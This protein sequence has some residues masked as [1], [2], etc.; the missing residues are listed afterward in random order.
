VLLVNTLIVTVAFLLVDYVWHGL[1]SPGPNPYKQDIL[2]KLIWT[3]VLAAAYAHLY[4]K[5]SRLWRPNSD[6]AFLF[7]N[8]V[9]DPADLCK[10]SWPK[11]AN[12]LVFSVLFSVVVILAMTLGALT[13]SAVYVYVL[14]GI[15]G[16]PPLNT[17]SAVILTQTVV[18]SISLEWKG[19]TSDDPDRG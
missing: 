4:N 2:E 1:I 19:R 3:I 15:H 12:G 5:A 9:V 18:A 17:D 13:L 14:H 8:R 10:I 6:D 7:K 11:V 16:D